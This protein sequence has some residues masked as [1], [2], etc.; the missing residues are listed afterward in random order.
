MMSQCDD[1]GYGGR[2]TALSQFLMKVLRPM[3]LTFAALAAV[4]LLLGSLSPAL[5]A[6]GDPVKGKLVF[7]QCRA[8]H[9]LTNKPRP[10]MGPNLN[11][12]F[13]RQAGSSPNYKLYSPALK[14][15]KFKWD[16][17]KLDHWLENPRTFLKGNRMV[18]A[19]IRDEQ[20]RQDLIAY[21]Q[22]AT[23]DPKAD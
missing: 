4:P 3:R 1:K 2:Y 7:N 23:V 18:F 20:K 11:G 21:L 17:D 19:G 8:C 15:A 13:G 10:K 22:K 5:A 6:P 12:L 14:A 16:P 9:W